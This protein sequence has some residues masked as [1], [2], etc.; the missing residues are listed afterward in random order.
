MS[1]N[2]KKGLLLRK[3]LEIED[4]KIVWLPEMMRSTEDWEVT[5]GRQR[6]RSLEVRHSEGKG[7]SGWKIIYTDVKAK[8]MME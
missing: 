2:N 6:M 1:W 7:A 8:D 3:K 5:N 4:I